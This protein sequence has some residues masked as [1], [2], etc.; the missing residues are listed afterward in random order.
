MNWSISFRLSYRTACRCCL[1][2]ILESRNT[3]QR[4]CHHSLSRQTT[5]LT[6]WSATVMAWIVF[7]NRSAALLLTA[8]LTIGVASRRISSWMT[9]RSDS[10]WQP[11]FP[12]TFTP[13]QSSN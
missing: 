13:G 9:L 1:L 2:W 5:L 10:Q 7:R 12:V 4:E 11:S 8:R 6:A 3:R